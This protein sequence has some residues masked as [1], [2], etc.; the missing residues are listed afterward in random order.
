MANQYTKFTRLNVATKMYRV[1]NPV[2]SV[3]EM[4]REFNMPRTTLRRKLKDMLTPSQY[5]YLT[6][7]TSKYNAYA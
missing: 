1:R 7:N 2:T 3:T 5:A 6:R 4:A